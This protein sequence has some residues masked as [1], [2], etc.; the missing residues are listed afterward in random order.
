MS[1]SVERAS[2]PQLAIAPASS[3]PAL[4]PSILGTD[5]QAALRLVGLAMAGRVLRN[6]RLYERLLVAAIVA[7]ALAGISK[8]NGLNAITRLVAWNA[9]ELQRIDR[10]ALRHSRRR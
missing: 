10:K 6:R 1:R 7:A 8:E 9:R 2:R 3:P 5:Q 4:R